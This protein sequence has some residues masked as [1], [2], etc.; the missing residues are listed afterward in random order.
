MKTCCFSSLTLVC[1]FILIASMAY[2]QFEPLPC[3]G[4]AAATTPMY[5][6]PPYGAP[7]PVNPY[8]PSPYHSPAPTYG[9]EVQRYYQAVA[10]S[11]PTQWNA[12]M[13]D[14]IGDALYQQEMLNIQRDRNYMLQQQLF[15]N[16]KPIACGLPSDRRAREGC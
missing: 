6:P 7:P 16:Q 2:A 8:A 13:P 4:C 14:P 3:Y 1:A 9:G 11:P 12:P 10:P 5:T 15:Q